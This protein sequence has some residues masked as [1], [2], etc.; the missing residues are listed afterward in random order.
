MVANV[1]QRILR[2]QSSTKKHASFSIMS[3][4][5]PEAMILNVNKKYTLLDGS[6]SLISCLNVLFIRPDI[7]NALM[8]N[9]FSRSRKISSP[10]FYRHTGY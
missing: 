5:A 10:M 3:K 4:L 9:Y 8:E 7:P 2:K 6:P 1:K